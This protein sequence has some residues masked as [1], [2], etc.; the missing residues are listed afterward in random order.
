MIANPPDWNEDCHILKESRQ[1]ARTQNTVMMED[2]H[3]H[4]ANEVN[5]MFQDVTVDFFPKAYITVSLIHE[6]ERY[7]S[8]WSAVV[9]D[10]MTPNNIY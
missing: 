2:V 4:H 8:I 10:V 3:F 6:K 7:L 1:A 9:E 5:V